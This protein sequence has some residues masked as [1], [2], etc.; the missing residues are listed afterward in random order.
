[1]K[2]TRKLYKSF[3]IVSLLL[4]MACGSKDAEISTNNK[5]AIAVTIASTTAENQQ[6]FLTASDK[7][8]AQNSAN[9]STRMMGFVTKLHTKVGDK[10]KKGQ[11]LVSINNT[12]LQA[13]A[14]QVNANITEAKAAYNSAEKDYK[15]F[16]NLY[17]D[18]AASQKELDDITTHY[19]MA[20]ARLEAAKQ[21]KNEI[22]AQFNYTNIRAPFAGVVT[23]TF[24][25]EGAMANPGV[26]LVE[27]ETPGIFE[28]I[29]MIPETEISQ[30]KTN[31]QAIVTVASIN[32]TILGVVTEVSTS[33]K[34]TG[35]Q[36]LVTINLDKQYNELR[37]GM[38]AT[39]QFPV[40]A[41]KKTNNK[42]LIPKK[43]IV[44]NGQLQGIYTVSQSN[45]AVL[46]WLRLG[47]SYGDQVE[48]LS[49]LSANETYIISAEGKLFN[50]VKISPSKSSGKVNSTKNNS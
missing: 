8:Q 20:K 46:R 12:D 28:V 1:M 21:M 15:R 48:V 31:Y 6:P 24:I 25:D 4:F 50:G 47:K 35:G 16:Q 37:S 13:K 42:I 49:G 11:L 5:P 40:E 45:T 17:A 2:T 32:K 34:N 30:I 43:A 19:Q 22:N 44:N 39:V 9:L 27:V 14:A 7:I 26:P 33:A 36:Y 10:V 29:A 23:N 41:T 3:L 38:F 18:N